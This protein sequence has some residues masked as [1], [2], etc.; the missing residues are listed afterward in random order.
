MDDSLD[1]LL[2]GASMIGMLQ[3]LPRAQKEPWGSSLPSSLV[4]LMCGR[5]ETSPRVYNSSLNV[6]IIFKKV[7]KTQTNEVKS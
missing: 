5:Q 2:L 3:A 1:P 6:F 7:L 4:Q